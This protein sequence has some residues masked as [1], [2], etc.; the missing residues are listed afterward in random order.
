MSESSIKMSLLY[1][2]HF[3]EINNLKQKS[4]IKNMVFIVAYRS[5]PRTQKK[6]EVS[7]EDFIALKNLG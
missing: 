7:E 1:V 2:L 4:Y 5:Y 6:S 3:S